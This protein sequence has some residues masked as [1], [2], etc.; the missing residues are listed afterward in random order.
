MAR[1]AKGKPEED[2][3]SRGST[4]K[5]AMPAPALQNWPG[6]R[7]RY[8]VP[9]GVG[10]IVLLTLIVYGQTLPIAA[11]DFDDTFYL[12]RNPYVNVA[13]AFSMLG[14]VWTTPYFGFF[15]PVTTTS[16]LL[17]RSLAD[18][19][20]PFDARPF[21][22]MQLVYAILC[23]GILILL[24]R[25]LGLPWILAVL[26]SVIFA[27]HP[28]H[29]EVVAWLA[30]RNNL[31]SLILLAG[32]VLAYLWARD[33][34]TANQ[35][36]LRHAATAVL[37]L[38]AILAK[39]V[40]VIIPVLLIAYEFCSERP[41]GQSTPM[42]KPILLRAVGLSAIFLGVG[43][44]SVA[45][46]RSLLLQDPLHGGWLIGVVLG[47]VLAMLAA[48]PGAPDLADF[49]A[50]RGHGLRV[51]AP[52]FVVQGLVFG[53]GCAWTIWA[54]VQAGAIKGGVPLLPTLN[55]TFEVM[56]RY[57]GR[58]LVPARMSASYVWVRFPDVSLQGV[59]GALL[60]LGLAA[61]GV[62]LAAMVVK[63][64][65]DRYR[66]LAAFGIFWYLIGY[67]PVSNL[68]PTSIKMA[69]RYQFVPSVGAILAV[70]ALA[71]ALF[72]SGRRQQ[73]A[74]CLALALVAAGYTA[75]SYQRARVW[76]GL[77]TPWKGHPDADLS[78]WTS[79]L[80]ADPDDHFALTSLALVYL[81]F[82]PPEPEKALPLLQRAM[83]VREAAQ[84]GIPGGLK[85]D[86]TQT[87]EAMGDAYRAMAL[88]LPEGQDPAVWQRQKDLYQKAAESFEEAA[89]TPFGFAPGDGRLQRALG[90]AL[91]GWARQLDRLA[92]ARLEVTAAGEGRTAAIRQRDELR[93][94]AEAAFRRARQILAAGNVSR[95][96][97]DFRDTV[98]DAGTRVFQREESAS[99]E[100]KPAVFRQA[101]ARYQ[102]A[103]ALFP[104]DPRVW[105]YEGLC[106]QRLR[107]AAPAADE[108]RRLFELGDAVLRKALTLHS[109]ASG[110]TPLL[111]YRALATMYFDAGDYRGA[112]DFLKQAQ[113]M[114]PV[115]SR[116]NSVD[117]DIQVVEGMLRK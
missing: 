2:P 85:L 20:K 104:D 35:W 83:Q 16:W 84:P 62:A 29:A 42:A 68:V 30:G 59:A 92:S 1:K 77:T 91:E 110:Y 10:L 23:A 100:E 49:R 9:T 116:T 43:G 24:Y 46:F 11:M 15:N 88:A 33:S 47:C 67:L 97:S 113:Q 80:E 106:Y 93:S 108:K 8:L 22:A 54:Q 90:N 78:L 3:H 111:P 57:A 7:S 76:S 102:D 99:A 5:P 98:L 101:L 112:L 96:D 40:S 18:K 79:A 14:P 71:A 82:D 72:P 25:R 41:G 28:I 12:L 51:L 66:R 114:D 70:L 61:G 21:R 52:P 74:T 75:W 117:R 64:P 86:A 94:R 115:A 4:L 37:T 73:V 103:E 36:R 45:V 27:V 39:P 69:D 89:L 55:L 38:L 95:D 53:A 31:T 34:A 107:A 56:L 81:R 6:E 19:T 65:G 105:L 58:V 63:G 50:G 87:L 44:A 48:A 17:D 109:T 26:G 60:V 32:A 13:D